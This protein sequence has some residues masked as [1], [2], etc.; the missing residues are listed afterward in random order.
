MSMK[1]WFNSVFFLLALLSSSVRAELSLNGVATYSE[2]G[3]ELFIAAL[4]SGQVGTNAQELINGIYP[5]RL[6]LK[7]LTSQ[8]ITQ[9]QFS[10]LWRE[11]VAINNTADAI[12]AQSHNLAY[13]EGLIR[14]RLEPN[15]HLVVAFSPSRGVFVSLNT[16]VLGHIRDDAFF[17]LLLKS[18]IGDVPSSTVFRDDL[19]KPSTKDSDLFSRFKAMYPRTARIE[20]ARSWPPVRKGKGDVR[21]PVKEGAQASRQTPAKNDSVSSQNV[22]DDKAGL[23]FSVPTAFALGEL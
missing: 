8:G 3:N 4:Y 1:Y 7:V 12:I 11:S 13:F 19:L 15:D 5:K 2:L 9:R 20:V 18:W 10:R 23:E 6:E 21:T 22:I 14:D 17:A 16:I